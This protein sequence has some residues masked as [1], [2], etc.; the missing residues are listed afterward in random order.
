MSFDRFNFRDFLMLMEQGVDLKK[1]TIYLTD[2][3]ESPTTEVVVHSIGFLNSPEHCKNF[4]DPI[5]LVVNSPGGYD[6]SLFYMYDA[7]VNSEA[8]IHTIGSGMVCSAA[9]L[10]L[11]SGD[12]RYCTE[13]CMF[14]THKGKVV[15]EGDDDEVRSTAILQ[16]KL[17]QK[18]WKLLA[19]HT[20]ESAQ[21]WLNKSK[22]EGAYWL[23]SQE[24]LKRGVIDGVL[25]TNRRVLTP[26]SNRNL[27]TNLDNDC[28]TCGT[29]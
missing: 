11:V 28:P 5:K 21:W 24:M 14:M 9:S 4:K 20:K 26:L 18:Y 1:R 29:K 3:I 13:N 22:N 16:E 27:K 25:P 12:K 2:A 17:S 8:E 7:I 15:I 6:D 19:R 10:I 23:D